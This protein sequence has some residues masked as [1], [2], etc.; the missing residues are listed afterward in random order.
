M[1]DVGIFFD[2]LVCICECLVGLVGVDLILFIGGVLVGEVDFFG[3]V[4]CEVGELIFWKLVIKFGK[5]LI[6]G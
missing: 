3:M 2:D 1:F 5:L 4:L 6:V